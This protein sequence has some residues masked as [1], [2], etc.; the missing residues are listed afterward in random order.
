MVMRPLSA[1]L[2][3]LCL[4]AS[5]GKLSVAT[6]GEPYD[7]GSPTLTEVWVSPTTG[8]DSNS[9]LQR[10]LPLKTLS[11]AWAKIPSG[12]TLAH[13][14]Y[15]INLLP[16]GYPCEPGPELDNCQNYF[17]DR[18]GT[19]DFPVILRAADGPGTVTLRG[20]LN[21]RNLSHFYLLDVTLVGGAALPTNS[22]GNNLLHFEGSDHV[23]V[24]G[25]TLAGPDC[26]NDTCNNLQEVLK[27]NQTQH[28]YV[29]DS[30]IGGAWHT[31]VDYFVVQHGHFLNNKV[32]TAGQWGMYVKGGS[33]HLRVEGNE[34]HHTHLG[35][36]AGQSANFAMMLSPWLHYEAY[37][38]KFVNNL[39]HDVAG[40]GVSVAGGYNI[41][42]AHNTL[43]RVATATEPGYP[44]MT[45]VHGER[46]CTATDELPEPVSVC[47]A[48][49]TA[50]GWGP[51]AETTG[52]AVIPNRNVLVYNNVL[53]NPTGQQTRYTH[54]GLEGSSGVP[55]IFHNI[56][57]PS[58]ADAGL[59][60]RGNIIWNGSVDLPT[61]AGETGCLD[62]NAS[63]NPTQLLLDNAINTVEPQLV[64]PAQGD[65][66]PRPG[67]GI[68]HWAALSIP[69]FTWTD[70]PA[71][72]VVAVGDLLNLV[73]TDR[74]GRMRSATPTQVGA[75]AS[76]EA[77]GAS[78]Q[79][80]G[81]ISFNPSTLQVGG[82]ST[83]SAS[84]S[85]GL[86]VVFSVDAIA[87][88]AAIGCPT[89]PQPVCA[90]SGNQVT[91]QSSGVCRIIAYQAGDSVYAPAMATQSI[92]VTATS[93]IDHYY[94]NILNRA[95]DDGGKSHWQ[96]EVARMTRLGVNPTEAYIAMASSFYNSE[97]FLGR[98][99][100]DEQYLQNLYLTFLNRA[101]DSTGLDSWK[102][103]MAQ[104]LPRDMVM[105]GF[106]FSTEFNNFMVQNVGSTSQRPEVGA[107]FDYYRGILGR[108]PEE[109]GLPYWVNHFRAA[110]CSSNPTDNVK[111]A[112]TA[113][114]TAFFGSAE[115]TGITPTPR[116]YVAD[117]YNAFMRRIAE[118]GGY[119]YWIDR[120]TNGDNTKEQARQ[121]FIDSPEFAGRVQAITAASCMGAMQ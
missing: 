99:M 2:W 109:G 28:L 17:S 104:G 70:A 16:G 39:M 44:M 67:G 98:S 48:N 112:A 5:A 3:C 106:M 34:F 65:F 21:L 121:A 38:I 86:P 115:Y 33:A 15:R 77:V 14:G 75:Y 12:N 91:A 72:P 79:T 103:L 50:G 95:P 64:D 8:A 119:N 54:F 23:L 92:T 113:I 47:Q 83:V 107:V 32:H 10:Q 117:L 74:D 87:T 19:F 88:C 62:Y 18:R 102:S 85:S 105:Y 46:N 24:R 78:P 49:A 22:S 36:Q 29:E 111:A 57:A 82:A 45:F 27:A 58:L 60:I 9:G 63:C 93:L 97:E 81:R 89:P 108:L 120:L 101:A 118:P 80:I 68:T 41:L 84:A 6:A 90:V 96:N 30:T 25:V 52:E 94:T 37:D 76:A 55:E 51:M 20:G 13:T 40:V 26:A 1:L 114:A 35:F 100:T 11:A 71:K 110:Q 73:A 42:I 43:Y 116:D 4:L 59:A 69:D 31:A 56:A 66:H 53:Y 7:V 61:G